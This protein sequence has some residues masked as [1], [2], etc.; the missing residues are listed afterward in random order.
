MQSATLSVSGMH[1]TDCTYTV[2]R[3]LRRQPG[4]A[5][6]DVSLDA[7]YAR[8]LFD[9]KRITPD[10]LAGAIGRA[11]YPAAPLRRLG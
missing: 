4:V 2:D 1:C 6:A 11:G 10:Q 5:E 3:L 8:V 7:G 9:P